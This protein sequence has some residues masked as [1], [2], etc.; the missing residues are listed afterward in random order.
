M[1][2]ILATSRYERALVKKYFLD[3]FKIDIDRLDIY[4]NSRHSL[5]KIEIHKIKSQYMSTILSHNN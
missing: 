3:K 5:E 4:K 1:L 2:N